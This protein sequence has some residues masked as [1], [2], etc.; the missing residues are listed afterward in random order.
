MSDLRLRL[1]FE[2]PTPTI[3]AVMLMD[4]YPSQQRSVF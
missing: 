3:L 4:P 2:T 1:S